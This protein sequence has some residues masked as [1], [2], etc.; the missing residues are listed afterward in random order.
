[1]TAK[2][3]AVAIIKRAVKDRRD[4]WFRILR[5]KRER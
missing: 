1:M 2:I 4:F 3:V 5:G